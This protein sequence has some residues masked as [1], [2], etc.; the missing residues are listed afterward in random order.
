MSR[1][2]FRASIIDLEFEVAR[3]LDY[4]HRDM[5]EE[6]SYVLSLRKGRRACKLQEAVEAYLAS[7][8]DTI[9]CTD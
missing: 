3:A 4:G 6:L 1:P 7:H 8:H 2:F 5:L 9:V